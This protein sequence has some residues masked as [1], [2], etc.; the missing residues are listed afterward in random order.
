M[1]LL[2]RTMQQNK[3]AANPPETNQHEENCYKVD[4]CELNHYRKHCSRIHSVRR[5][6]L[7]TVGKGGGP[8]PQPSGGLAPPGRGAAVHRGPAAVRR[9]LAGR[10]RGGGSAGAG[11][12]L[13]RSREATETT[14]QSPSLSAVTC[15][16]RALKMTAGMRAPHGD[17]CGGRLSQ[18]LAWAWMARVVAIYH[19]SG[20]PKNLLRMP[21]LGNTAIPR[22][23][24]VFP[25]MLHKNPSET[26]LQ[27]L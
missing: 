2:L 11:Q 6:V 7:T 27:D 10:A 16:L 19:C 25:S 8:A 9:A 4:A 24:R 5:S 13:H 14:T 20:K 12:N 18:D 26:N 1:Y 23:A 3:T 21:Q 15:V 17:A 22:W